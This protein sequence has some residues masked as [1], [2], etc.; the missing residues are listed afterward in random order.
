MV[1]HLT[2]SFQIWESLVTRESRHR[3]LMPKIERCTKISFCLEVFHFV[4]V[5]R[6]KYE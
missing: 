6:V 5:D 2:K 4:M 3:P 1:I